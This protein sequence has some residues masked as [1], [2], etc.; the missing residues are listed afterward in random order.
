LLGKFA[1]AGGHGANAIPFLPW[2]S[3]I[4]GK[5]IIARFDGGALFSGGGPLALCKVEEH[6]GVTERLAG[7]IDDTR[8]PMLIKHTLAEMPRFRLLM[9]AVAYEDANTAL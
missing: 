6:L 4:E 8:A 2:L 3:L 9:I 5:P 7:C 1:R